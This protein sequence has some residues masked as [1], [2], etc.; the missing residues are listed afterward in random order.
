MRVFAGLLLLASLA[1]ARD[2]G[3]LLRAAGLRCACAK[4]T[5]R[6]C[7][8]RVATT[9]CAGKVTELARWGDVARWRITLRFETPIETNV[10]GYERVQM[11]LLAVYGGRL[12][13]R[14]LT[15]TARL[16]PSLEARVTYLNELPRRDTRGRDPLLVLR[17]GPGILDVR[18]FPVARHRP[19][20]VTLSAYSLARHRSREGVRLY[21]TGRRYLAIVAD[22][23]ERKAP[24]DFVDTAGGRY[25]YFLSAKECR[26]RFGD[27]PVR[28]VPCVPHLETAVTG[29]GR[30]A[31]GQ[32]MALAAFPR[33]A[34]LPGHE[35]FAAVP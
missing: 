20:Y 35:F 1:A 8:R 29:R 19:A 28:P 25:L 4:V 24:A 30:H 32:W 7:S 15:L 31:A 16:R 12:A 22:R 13:Q 10:E 33:R 5:C 23:P 6:T 21:R 26:A 17:R 14:N 27:R 11:P 3:G 18:V 2:R 34:R 9:Y